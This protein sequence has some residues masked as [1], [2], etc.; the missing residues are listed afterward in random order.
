MV[1]NQAQYLLVGFYAQRFHDSYHVYIFPEA[2]LKLK[3][4]GTQEAILLILW[5][6]S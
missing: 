2:R 4:V 3:K 1:A 5:H 6:M